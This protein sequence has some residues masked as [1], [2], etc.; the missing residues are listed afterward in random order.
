MDYPNSRVT[1]KHHRYEPIASFDTATAPKTIDLVEYKPYLFQTPLVIKQRLRGPPLPNPQPGFFREERTALVL[2][3]CH[4]A[5]KTYPRMIINVSKPSGV[6][7]ELPGPTKKSGLGVERGGPP[8]FGFMA[9][10]VWK[11]Y[12][13][14]STRSIVFSAVAAS[15]DAIGSYR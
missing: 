2:R 6:L 1:A 8:A 5:I 10:G 7:G 9:I 12:G 13:L 15:R 14:Y 3:G 4:R 11:R